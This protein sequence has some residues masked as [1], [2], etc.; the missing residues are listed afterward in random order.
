MSNEQE[1]A[2]LERKVMQSERVGY[3]YRERLKSIRARIDE[4][5]TA[6]ADAQIKDAT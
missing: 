6:D 5:R 3:G 2:D 4:L 1:I